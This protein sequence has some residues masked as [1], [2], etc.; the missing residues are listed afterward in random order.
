M[1][2]AALML[3][4][5]AAAPAE[6]RQPAPL[7]RSEIKTLSE[8]A[9]ARRIFGPL[10]ADL[11]ATNMTRE[12]GRP[13]EGA[14]IWFWTKPR[15]DWL[16]DGLCVADRTI[17]YL[18]PDL[19]AVGNNPPLRIAAMETETV[20]IVRDRKMATKLSG[21]DPDEL[22]GQDEA[23]AKLDPRRDSIAA[24]SGWQLM[25]AFELM[26][27]LGDGAR[28]GR[29]AVPIDCKQIDFSGPPPASEAE[30]LTRLSSL[31]EASVAATRDCAEAQATG[32]YC[33]R[34]QTYD[35]FIYFFLSFPGQDLERVIVRGMEDTSSIE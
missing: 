11:Y 2:L 34:V 3:A 18:A 13:W 10:G 27:K 6:A 30:C 23:C 1:R 19:L 35:S 26:K 17:V 16:R 9:L 21:F 12:S 28:A 20:Y 29:T 31:G 14:R 8:E 33:I 15:K 4:L 7:T 25:T 32:T 22:K 24:E 5:L